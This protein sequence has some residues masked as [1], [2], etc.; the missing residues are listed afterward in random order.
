M[1][2]FCSLRY[3]L[4]D[5]VLGCVPLPS[6]LLYLPSFVFASPEVDATAMAEG[7]EQRLLLHG[8][9]IYRLT[10]GKCRRLDDYTAA[11]KDDIE[12]HRPVRLRLS[13]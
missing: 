5:Q 2:Y 7:D 11:I 9:A 6:F 12:M 3:I 4:L 1:A 13:C 8:G 10:K